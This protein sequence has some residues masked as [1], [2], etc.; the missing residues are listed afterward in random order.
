MI[1][2]FFL[3]PVE[4][5]VAL[6]T[7]FDRLPDHAANNLDNAA[8][9]ALW[10]AMDASGQHVSLEGED[11]MV[12]MASPEG[13]WVFDLPDA[14]TFL[15]VDLGESERRIVADRWAQSEELSFYKLSGAELIEPIKTLQ[16]LASAAHARGHRLLLRMAM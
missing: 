13:P 4:D 7:D 5:A 1:T 11:H 10:S 12:A 8:L 16:D 15:L 6:C 2:D 14:M 3:A 9:A